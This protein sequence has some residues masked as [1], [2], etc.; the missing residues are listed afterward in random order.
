MNG[1]FD[2][3]VGYFSSDNKSGA[4][5]ASGTADPGMIEGFKNKARSWARDVLRLYNTDVSG[6]PDLETRKK[7]LLK[8][9]K[10]IKMGIESVFGTLEELEN[11][12]LGL[13]PLI[14]IAAI[15]ASIGAITKWASDYAIFQDKL[16]LHQSLMKS[17]ASATEASNVVEKLT[18]SKPLIDFGGL[19]PIAGFG[20]LGFYLAT[21]KKG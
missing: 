19:I 15:A 18:S 2:S 1:I 4:N 13:L 16:K 6:S 10:Y 8:W 20:L 5:T 17:G 14:P 9:A 12:N 3:V 11:M 21:R 7:S